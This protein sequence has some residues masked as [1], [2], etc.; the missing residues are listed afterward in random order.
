MYTQKIANI[1]DHSQ[2]H[3][4]LGLEN[5]FLE[6]KSQRILL[7]S[8]GLLYKFCEQIWRSS[9]QPF[10]IFIHHIWGETVLF[11]IQTSDRMRHF[12]FFQD[13]LHS[14]NIQA[15]QSWALSEKFPKSPIRPAG[16]HFY[17]ASCWCGRVFEWTLIELRFNIIYYYYFLLFNGFSYNDV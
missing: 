2:D 7:R 5:K 14:V 3:S 17:G 4:R 15:D 1:F 8:T 12:T 6:N 10:I 11:I 16:S 9:N 13:K